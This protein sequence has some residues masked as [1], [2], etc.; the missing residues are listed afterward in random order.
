MK[1][2]FTIIFFLG[3]SQ[4]LAQGPTKQHFLI[5]PAGSEN[6][7]AIEEGPWYVNIENQEAGQQLNDGEKTFMST[8]K[9]NTSQTFPHKIS[10]QEKADRLLPDP[11]IN[12]SFIA[13]SASS[14]VPMDNYMAISDSGY[15]ASVSNTLFQVYRENGTLVKS[16][17]L[18]S[19]A[20]V[21]RSQWDQQW[22]I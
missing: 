8:L 13:N 19:F 21:F 4:L 22:K 6:L 3:A 14:S 7:N 20:H 5:A 12:T 16:R 1:Q 10:H 17:T 2:V 15:I 11:V 9:F 18:Q